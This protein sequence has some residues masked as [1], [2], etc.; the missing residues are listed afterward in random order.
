MKE[1]REVPT[2]GIG[3][4]CCG[5]SA[6]G[7]EIEVISAKAYFCPMCPGQEGDSPGNCAQ[8]GMPLQANSPFP[9]SAETTYTC[10][11]HPEVRSAGPGSCTE[12]GMDLEPVAAQVN[13]PADR[14]YG[15]LK[16]DFLISA[17]FSSAVLFLAMGHVLPGVERGKWIAE[18]TNHWLQLLFTTPVILWAG[19]T[20]Q[21]RFW[22]SLRHRNPNMWTLIGIGTSTAYLVSIFALALPSLFSS[23][24]QTEGRIPVYFESAAVITTLVLLGQILESRARRRTSEALRMLINLSPPTAQRVLDSGDEEIAIE[25]ICKGD[26]LRVRPGEKVPVDGRILD[27]SGSVDESMLS[28]EPLPVDK[29]IDD[30]VIAGTTNMAGAFKMVAEAVGSETILARIIDLVS[31]AQR[32]RAPIQRSVDRVA[33]VFVPAVIGVSVITFVT[34][35]LWGPEPSYAYALVNAIA[36][37][38]IVCPCALGLATP[39]S[40]MVALGKGAQNGILVRDAEALEALREVDTLVI[41][42]TGTLTEGKPSV[43]AVHLLE[44]SYPDR[45]LQWAASLEKNSEHP[46]AR[47]LL[48]EAEASGVSLLEPTDFESIPGAGIKGK[49]DGHDVVCGSFRLLSDEGIPQMQRLQE[50]A[51]DLV[52]ENELLTSIFLAVDGKPAGLIAVEDKLKPTSAEAIRILTDHRNLDVIML[53]GDRRSTAEALSRTLGIADFHAE[54]SPRG[55]LEFVKQLEKAGKKVA[56]AGDG[57]NDAPALAAAYVGI[58]MGKGTEVAMESAGITLMDGDLLGIDRALALSLA[59]S[60][61]IRENLFF[62]FIYNTLGILIAAGILYPFFGLLLNPMLAS[63]AMSLSSVSVIGN[64]LRLKQLELRRA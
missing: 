42:K 8:C 54:L 40:I 19:R 58:A 9:P 23:A 63:A 39:M 33:S 4:A 35:S 25:A 7:V 18:S 36:V 5:H 20:I 51:E 61:N 24:F 17:L 52:I 10:P 43:R 1:Q 3:E 30:R 56:V 14:E 2:Q 31:Q 47:A 34:W 57:I 55:K 44:G 48:R 38:I 22:A 41:D 60:R 32:S 6:D 37:L 62:A 59:T 16:Q 26:T 12:C 64:A 46:V 27:G 28:G 15:K 49:V 50:L 11:M 53:T 29:R 45:L 21:S 13:E